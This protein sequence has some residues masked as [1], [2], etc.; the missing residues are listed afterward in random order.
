MSAPRH[1]WSGDWQLESAA[2]A[3]ELAER[4]GQI[5]EPLEPEA[6]SAPVGAEPSRLARVIAWLRDAARRLR[7]RSPNLRE[8]LRAALRARGRQ[9]RV[10]LLVML[11]AL[12]G[13][14]AAWGVTSLLGGS[15]GQAA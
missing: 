9:V 5:A 15:G 4:R 11:V 13:A 6:E 8:R 12:V 14:G 3:E 10:V 7:Q 2:A 1:L